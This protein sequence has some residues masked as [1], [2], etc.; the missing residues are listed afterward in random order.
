ML[1]S[2]HKLKLNN[3]N[4]C[5]SEEAASDILRSCSE[6]NY[7]KLFS[8][9]LFK[10]EA[11]IPST[12]GNLL[13]MEEIPNQITD[14]EVYMYLSSLSTIVWNTTQNRITTY[15]SIISLSIIEQLLISFHYPVSNDICL[16]KY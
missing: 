11:F 15:P 5:L 8:I 2:C 14:A 16:M 3:F 1:E 10:C 4:Y 6:K 9:N 7:Y 12:I 13:K